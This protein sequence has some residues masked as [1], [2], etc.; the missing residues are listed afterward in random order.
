[1]R[2]AIDMEKDDT[3][4]LGYRPLLDGLRGI[5]LIL[6]LITHFKFIRGGFPALDIFFVLSRFLITILLIEEWEKRKTISLRRFYARRA[7]RLYPAYFTVLG[8]VSFIPFCSTPKN[9]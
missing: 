4:H 1:M 3:F 8:F 7:L 2:D 9:T 5:G 6:V